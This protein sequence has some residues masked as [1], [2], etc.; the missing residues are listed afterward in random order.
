MPMRSALAASIVLLAVAGAQ[1]AP[2]R[3]TVTGVVSRG[4]IAP[5][6]VAE[7]ACDEPAANV[8][9]VFVR[10]GTT[11]GRAVANSA[12]RYRVRLAP[13]SYVV[14]R[15]T[16]RAAFDRKLQPGRVRVNAGRVTRVNFSIDTGIR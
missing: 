8:T 9:L 16:V 13:G 10:R 7:Q 11:A 4:P 5:V 6:C 12:G 2:S 3:G 1:A 15:A 14:R